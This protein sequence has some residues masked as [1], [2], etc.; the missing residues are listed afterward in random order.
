MLSNYPYKEGAL[1]FLDEIKRLPVC[2]VKDGRFPSQKPAYSFEHTRMG[3]KFIDR[4]G[5]FILYGGNP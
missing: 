5:D 1:F 2:M 3:V 4:N